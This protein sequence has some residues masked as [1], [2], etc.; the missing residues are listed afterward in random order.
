M[1]R[2]SRLIKVLLEQAKLRVI[3][4]LHSLVKTNSSKCEAFGAIPIKP[5]SL[6][7]NYL[8]ANFC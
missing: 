5:Q 8:K 7:R 6:I 4:V 2:D 3:R 1:I